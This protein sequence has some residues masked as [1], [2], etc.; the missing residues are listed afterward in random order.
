MEY[1]FGCGFRI[2]LR[3]GGSLLFMSCV[4]YN[5]LHMALHHWQ[6][7][8]VEFGSLRNKRYMPLH[9]FTFLGKHTEEFASCI[10]NTDWSAGLKNRHKG[11]PH[12]L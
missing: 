7:L 8:W 10:D 4:K 6:V 12:S 2:T 3:A 1:L 5:A 9:V 11:I